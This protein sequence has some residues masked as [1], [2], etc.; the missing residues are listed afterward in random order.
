[1]A[2]SVRLTI[3]WR[4]DDS[5]IPDAQQEA[6]TQAVYRSLRSIDGIRSVERI[7]DPE[8]PAG[9]MGKHWLWSVLTA[10]IP[11]DGFRLACEEALDQLAGKPIKFKV[12]VEGKSGKAQTI[13]A[14]NVRPDNVIHIIDK[15]VEAAQKL[16]AE[17]S[18]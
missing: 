5:P 7:A 15:L 14:E 13:E 9:A 12:E 11:G 8:A 1:M 10:E 3:D 16:Q 6:F 4:E 2:E 17:D 18:E